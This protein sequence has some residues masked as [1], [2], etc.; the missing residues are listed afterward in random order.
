MNGTN[1]FH[2]CQSVSASPSHGKPTPWTV[3][4]QNPRSRG[5]AHQQGSEKRDIPGGRDLWI[6][7][8]AFDQL[9]L[10]PDE[11]AGSRVVRDEK[12]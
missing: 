7:F 9:D 8:G 3:K 4:K 2:S 1:A 6:R 11:L 10:L 12:A 5:S